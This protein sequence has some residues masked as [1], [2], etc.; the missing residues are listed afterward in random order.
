MTRVGKFTIQRLRLNR[1]LLVKYRLNKQSQQKEKQLLLRY[2]DLVD[3]LSLL[4]EQFELLVVEQQKL[5]E[6]QRD[7]LRLILNQDNSDD[8][9]D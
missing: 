4:N 3:L 7:L 5:L 9:R 2:R 8:E 1:P 6:Q